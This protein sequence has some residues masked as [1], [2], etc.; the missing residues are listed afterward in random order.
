MSD[1]LSE[2]KATIEALIFAAPEPLT[3]NGLTRILDGEPREHIEE[4]LVSLR[5]EWAN[6]AGGLLFV[7]L[8]LE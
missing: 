3:L 1:D 6:R 2:L 4:A 7:T 5:D 8:T